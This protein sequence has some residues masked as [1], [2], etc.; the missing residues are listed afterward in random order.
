MEVEA[1]VNSGGQLSVKNDFNF[2]ISVTRELYFTTFIGIAQSNLHYR[3]Q[4]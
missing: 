3:A 1:E 4:V 2:M